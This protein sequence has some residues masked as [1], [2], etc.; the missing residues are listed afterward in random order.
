MENQLSTEKTKELLRWNKPEV[1][2]LTI[3]ED[4]GAP[5]PGSSTG[6]VEQE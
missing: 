4:T 2:I 6:L 3:S 1:R 5:L